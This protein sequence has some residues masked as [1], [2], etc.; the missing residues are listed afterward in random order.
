MR[1]SAPAPQRRVGQD[2][3]LPAGVVRIEG[4]KGDM[5][6]FRL[7][8][9]GPFA[10]GYS[11]CAID[12]LLEGRSVQW[13]IVP[14]PPGEY[15]ESAFDRAAMRGCREALDWLRQRSLLPSEPQRIRIDFIGA[16]VAD[17]DVDFARAVALAAVVHLLRPDVTFDVQ[18]QQDRWVMTEG[19]ESE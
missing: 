9:V 3:I 6:R 10:P 1:R 16:H 12:L 2:C 4:G 15:G 11:R 7:F 19:A 17:T 8:K 5:P 18:W 13:E 14:P